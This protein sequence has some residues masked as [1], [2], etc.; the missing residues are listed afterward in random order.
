M[1]KEEKYKILVKKHLEKELSEFVLI[2]ERIWRHIIYKKKQNIYSNIVYVIDSTFIVKPHD[3][4]NYL[5]HEPW[6]D[7]MCLQLCMEQD[8]F[9]TI[10]IEYID[11]IIKSKVSEIYEQREEI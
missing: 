3:N 5:F 2:V 1:T 7:H 8:E 11:P 10:L 4:D 6:I 9:K